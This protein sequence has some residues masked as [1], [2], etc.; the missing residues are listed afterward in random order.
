[1]R[2][3]LSG[4]VALLVGCSAFALLG[5]RPAAAASNCANNNT[6]AW[7]QID[8]GNWQPNSNQDPHCYSSCKQ[9]AQN[10]DARLGYW[11]MWY[12]TGNVFEQKTD[13][14]VRTWNSV[15]EC[16]PN[17][18][19]TG[20]NTAPIQYAATSMGK[21]G[22]CGSTVANGYQNGSVIYIQSVSINLNSD[23]DYY[24]GPVPSS[25]DHGCDLPHVDLHE[26]G[27]S[28][29]EGHSS[30]TSDVMYPN[31]NGVVSIDADAHHMLAATYGY[32]SPSSCNSCQFD[33]GLTPPVHQM[34]VGYWQQATTDKVN[35]A[36]GAA[37]STEQD[38]SGT[39]SN[40]VWDAR[41]ADYEVSG[42]CLYLPP[43]K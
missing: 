13:W 27:H 7:T 17:Y 42:T 14:A 6:C 22:L 20:D 34:G 24:D 30:V 40:A 1:M 29:G 37:E 39:T 3:P 36:V 11:D 28:F 12:G 21:Y 16:T 43:P 19:K 25:D 26:T 5:V 8:N 2:R 33:F 18:S 31:D 32:D 41:C 15:P 4:V 10:C 9:W 23:K 35:G 38:A